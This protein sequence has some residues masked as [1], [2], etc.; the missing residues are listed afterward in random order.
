MPDEIIDRPSD[1]DS[2]E[3]R[4]NDFPRDIFIDMETGAWGLV[5][6]L[7]V[8]RQA[9]LPDSMGTGT[10]TAAD[11]RTAAAK[12]GLRVPPGGG[13]PLGAHKADNLVVSDRTLAAEFTDMHMG[14]P[15]SQALDTGPT[16]DANADAAFVPETSVVKVSCDGSAL[17]NPSG[18][19]G[20]CWF[21]DDD[22]WSADGVGVASNN[23]MEL[24]ALLRFLQV[25]EADVDDNGLLCGR[26]T[27]I[28]CDSRYV[29]DAIT[30]WAK[31]WASNGWRTK[32][33]G[34]VKN[35]ELIRAI[36]LMIG[37]RKQVSFVWVKGHAGHYMNTRADAGAFGASTAVKE[38]G[39]VV[40]GPGWS[41]P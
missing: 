14:P 9:E 39:A 28:E 40:T 37:P 27:V 16:S 13:V 21:V 31:G 3:W 7:R 19:G 23:Q 35:V 15:P 10:A 36:M 33:G 22:R 5:S 18:P 11:F 32:S 8:I 24:T 2:P 26:P 29:I 12:H 41:R 6:N 17:G 30:K 38:G 1:H 20:W 25:S 4:D 34:D